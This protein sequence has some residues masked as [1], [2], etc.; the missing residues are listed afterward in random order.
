M[1][2]R[3]QGAAYDVGAAEPARWVRA[4]EEYQGY[5]GDKSNRWVPLQLVVF[6]AALTENE[7]DILDSA[8]LRPGRI[9]RKIEFPPPGT[10]AR[11]C[12]LRIH[13]RKGVVFCSFI[14]KNTQMSL[15]RRINQRALAEKMGL[16]WCRSEGYMY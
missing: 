4:V 11:L 5:Y 9:D 7:A 13:S 1:W 12:I 10:E 6:V 2:R 15:Q 14:E 3:Q 8:L 16:L